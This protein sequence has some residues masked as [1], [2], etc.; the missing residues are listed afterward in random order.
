[1]Q[2]SHP[3]KATVS[4]I[5]VT[6]NAADMLE[7]TLRSIEA[8]RYAEMETI[9]VDGKS[10]DGTVDIIRKHEG[11]VSKWVSEPDGGIYDAMNKGVRMASGEWIIF[12]N[13]G[14]TFAGDDVLERI[15]STK[16]DADIIYGDVVKGGNVKKAPEKYHPYHRMLFC[17]QSSLTRR[18]LLLDCPFDTSH[19]LSAD[20]K[21]FLTQY[22]RKARFHYVGFPIADFDTTGVSNSRRSAG[23]SD[24]MRVISETVPM[25]QRLAFLLRLMVPYVICRIRGK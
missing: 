19:R 1:M 20:L 10:K 12:M 22:F 25:P 3:L 18:K 2:N 15:F 24:N 13:A 16:Q 8:Q 5:T 23:L 9:I 21:F 11:A 6:Y 17:H 14:D 4:V 7:R